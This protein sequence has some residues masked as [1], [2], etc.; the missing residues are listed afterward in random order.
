MDGC[1]RCTTGAPIGSCCTSN[2]VVQPANLALRNAWFSG[3]VE[4][5]IG[6]RGHS[7]TTMDTLH[8]AIVEGP[9]GD[10]VLRLWEWERIRGVVFQIDLWMP[11]SSAV[12]LARTRIRNVNDM[13]TPMYW[14]T[15][16]AITVSADTRVI[17]PATRAFRTEYP[18][19]LRV[20]GVPDDGDGDVTFPARQA[21]AADFFFDVAAQQ[22]PWIVA[23]GGD[24]AGTAHVST[25]ALRGRKLF[26]WGTGRGG[27]RW[28]QWLSHGGDEVYAEIQGGLAPTQFEHVTMPARA[29]CSWTEAFGAISV[30]ATRSHGG[31]WDEAVGHVGQAVNEMVSIERLDTWHRAAGA[32]ADRPP[33]EIVATGSGWGAVERLRRND[34]GTAWFDDAGTP[35]PDST[36]GPDQEDWLTL[37]RTGQLPPRSP[38]DAPAS[39]VTGG[40][41]ERRL[42]AA[43]PSWLTEYFGAV[44][45]HGRGDLRQATARYQ[46]SLRHVENAWALRGLAE[47]AGSAGRLGESAQLAV[48]AARTAPAEWRLVAEAVERLLDADRP[49]DALALLDAR[50]D[51]GRRRGR[52]QLLEAWAAHAAGDVE[53]AAAVL[54]GGLEV[55]DL[56]EGERSVDRLWS[57]VFPERPLPAEYDFRMV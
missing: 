25:A 9:G 55:A 4:W 2:P 34:A 54:A 20:T 21:K 39:Y 53:R 30:D 42:D 17:A 44:L 28:Q 40:D 6:T 49:R 37:L 56:R 10:P 3:G 15:N 43:R 16:A 57:A 23:V 24:G 11:S 47:A 27:R 41:W 7:P 52:L 33:A 26:V 19:G 1:C 8:A 22:R 5:N 13:A 35:F 36:C 31:D 51:A 12:L 50:P 45:A 29:E 18:S 14:W 46:A 38:S 32:V 48:R